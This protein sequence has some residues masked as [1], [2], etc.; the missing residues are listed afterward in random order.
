[1]KEPSGPPQH[2]DPEDRQSRTYEGWISVYECS[3][4]FEADLVRDRLDEAGVAAVVL[5][6]RDHSFNLNVGDMAPVHVMVRPGDERAAR[7]IVNQAPLSDEE[8]EA[9]AMSADVMAPDAHDPSAEAR[10]DSG[11]E[12]ISLDVPDDDEA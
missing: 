12:E 6:Q 1:M 10:L 3:T 8:L 2:N 5:T 4:D 7:D 9:A 11:I